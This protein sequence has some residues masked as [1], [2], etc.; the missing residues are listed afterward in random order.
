MR[1]VLLLAHEDSGQE[2]RLQAA[3]DL[4]RAFDGHLKCL[5]VLTMPVVIGDFYGASGEAILLN[6]IQGRAAENR[7]KLEARIAREDVRWS[8]EEATGEIAETLSHAA[9][10]SD[11]IVLNCK[12]GDGNAPDMRDITGRTAIKSGKPIVA[13][14][15]K[16]SGFDVNGNVVIAWDGSDPVAR[17]MKA[18][19]PLLKLASSVCL[20]TIEDGSTAVGTEE[21]AAYL[22]RHDIRPDIRVVA[23]EGRKADDVITDYCRQLQASYCLMGAYSRSRLSEAL[24]GGV[25]RR[26]LT[27]SDLPLVLGH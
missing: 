17:T 23:D 5:T 22:S 11:V 9:G 2:A 12:L 19:V 13:M 26:M 6:D 3:L 15:E 14:P 8:W 24:F 10:L 18:S 16:S 25:T 20:L 27:S 7:Q 1:N 4:V 21:A